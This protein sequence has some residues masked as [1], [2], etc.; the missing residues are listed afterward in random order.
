MALYDFNKSLE[1]IRDFLE[2]IKEEIRE[3]RLLE[4]ECPTT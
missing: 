2:N 4:E 1:A 3:R